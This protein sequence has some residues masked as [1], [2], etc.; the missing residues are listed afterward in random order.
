MSFNERAKKSSVLAELLE[1]HIWKQCEVFGIRLATIGYENFIPSDVRDL[2]INLNTPTS[3]FVRFL[4]D[5]VLVNR[6]NVILV[7]YKVTTTPRYTLEDKQW[8]YG[9]VEA[10]AYENYLKLKEMG[11]NVAILNYCSYHKRPFLMDY[12][13][14]S[15]I[16][17]SPRSVKNTNRGS[18]TLYYNIKL[19]EMRDLV[20]F[21]EQE[22]FIPS[23]SIRDALE[24]LK[25]EIKLCPILLTEHH[26]KSK[27]KHLE[28]GWN[29][30]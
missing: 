23:D 14:M 29:W 18:G 17:G 28:T 1:K 9:Q 22:L 19:Y 26:P 21:L 30:S 15:F 24:K 10:R 16:E 8:G 13:D 7:D 4:P 3:L 11:I 27:Y 20:S 12:V 6:E 2:L 25:D 5:Y